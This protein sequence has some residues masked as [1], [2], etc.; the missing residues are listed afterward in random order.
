MNI[1][2]TELRRQLHEA[3][4]TVSEGKTVTV[5]K[6]GKTIAVLQPPA[7]T[8]PVTPATPVN[9]DANGSPVL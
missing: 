7:E 9:V 5:T 2:A 1:T 4:K 3:L 6:H 8:V